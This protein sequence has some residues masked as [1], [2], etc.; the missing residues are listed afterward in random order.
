MVYRIC[1]AENPEIAF[2]V[3]VEGVGSGGDYAVPMGRRIL[4]TY[5][6]K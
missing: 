5:F 1:S 6:E 2:T 4:D 3:I